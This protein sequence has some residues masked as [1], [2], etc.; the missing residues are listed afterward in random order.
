MIEQP[1]DG[2]D[3][4]KVDLGFL[5]SHGTVRIQ[6]FSKDGESVG[7][8]FFYTEPFPQKDGHS[9]NI[10]ITNK[11]VIMGTQDGRIHF[12]LSDPEAQSPTPLRNSKSFLFKDWNSRWFLHPDPVVDLCCMPIG[13]VS[14]RLI[15]QNLKLFQVSFGPQHLPS[16]EQLQG[17]ST[18]EEV[19]MAGYPTGM[20]D[21][22]HNLPLI[23]KGITA[24]H[25][26]NDFNDRQEFVVDMACFPGSSG[27]PVIRPNP[28]GEDLP[29]GYLLG[30][31]YAI[32]LYGAKGEIIL[33]HEESKDDSM[34]TTTW[35][36]TH[37][38]FVIKAPAVRKLVDELV[39]AAEDP[40]DP[41]FN[42]NI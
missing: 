7:T 17:M 34:G 33:P 21:E 24:T 37:L 28:E 20:W 29:G 22:A 23:R 3:E 19:L 12:H 38:G 6:G 4:P 14:G 30:V 5:L 42:M 25:P 13:D 36:P 2:V 32:P 26:G 18:I 41:R 8:G 10:V 15:E 40:K 35:L 11:H 31:L 27:S 1:Q 16:S 9:V 39:A